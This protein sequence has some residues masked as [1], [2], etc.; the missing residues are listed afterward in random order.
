[1]QL[2]LVVTFSL[3]AFHSLEE[4][5]APHEHLW[6]IQ[7]GLKG[8]LNEGRVVSLTKAQSLFKNL[9][10][11]LCGTFLNDNNILDGRCRRNPTCENLALFLYP[12]FKENL[13]QLDGSEKLLISF[14]QVGVWEETGQLGFARVSV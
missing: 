14:I 9:T 8:D 13:N 7:V 3:K 11:P 5:E 1:M 4:R 10:L 2:E 6:D 12:L